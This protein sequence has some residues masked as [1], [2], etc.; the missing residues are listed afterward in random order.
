MVFV[1]VRHKVEDYKTWKQVF[2]DF[3]QTRKSGGEKSYQIF[4]TDDNPNDLNLLFQWDNM[5]NAQSFMQSPEL[6]SAMQKAGVKDQPR[7]EY[8][9]ELSSGEL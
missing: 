6:K 3:H 2:D 7:I 5:S 9:E 4:Q 1:T 8:L